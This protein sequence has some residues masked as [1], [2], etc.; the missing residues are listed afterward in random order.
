MGFLLHGSA[1][2]FVLYDGRD[3]RPVDPDNGSL[4][5]DRLIGT[6]L[7]LL[8]DGGIALPGLLADLGRFLSSFVEKSEGS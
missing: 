6:L 5:S 3:H 7:E 1:F 8:L 2:A 4:L